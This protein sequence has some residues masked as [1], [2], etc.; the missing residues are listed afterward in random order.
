MNPARQLS[1][2]LHDVRF[3]SRTTPEAEKSDVRHVVQIRIRHTKIL[4]AILRHISP[5]HAG[6]YL[7]KRLLTKKQKIC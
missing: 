6:I 2:T 4:S 1:W 3:L 5:R 7:I